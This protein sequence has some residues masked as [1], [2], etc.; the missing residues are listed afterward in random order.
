MTE[1]EWLK[2][3]SGLTDDELKTYE[4]ILGNG[5]FQA[6]LKK[7]ISANEA[8]ATEAKTAKGELAVHH[9]L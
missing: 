9:P 3:E 8:L 1:L 5:K 2:Q 7:V 6:M 4:T